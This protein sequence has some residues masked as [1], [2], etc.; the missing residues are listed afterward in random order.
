MVCV[1]EQMIPGLPRDPRAV[2]KMPWNITLQDVTGLPMPASFW[3]RDVKEAIAR[4]T[5][6]PSTVLDLFVDWAPFKQLDN[7][8]MLSWVVLGRVRDMDTGPPGKPFGLTVFC[9]SQAP[10]AQMLLGPLCQQ[11]EPMTHVTPRAVLSDAEG[12]ARA[13]ETKHHTGFHSCHYCTIPGV[14]VN[15]TFNFYSEHSYPARTHDEFVGH[16]YDGTHRTGV[17][18]QM[19]PLALL[20]IDIVKDVI[21]GDD[22]HL[23]NGVVQNFFTIFTSNARMI[24]NIV[25]TTAAPVKDVNS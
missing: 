16:Q 24:R 1:L 5:A 11:L 19:T 8:K 18:T 9:G 23:L 21:V 25:V 17:R 15:D 12:R 22:R 4:Q 13:K 2:L 6:R 3:Q 7:P 20:R 10:T 14:K